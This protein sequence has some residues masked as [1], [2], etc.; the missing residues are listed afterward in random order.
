ML[1]KMLELNKALTHLNLSYNLI[2]DLGAQSIF[3]GLQH[4][5]T[6]VNLNLKQT[7]IRAVMTTVEVLTKMLQLNKALTHLNL[8]RNKSKICHI[9]RYLI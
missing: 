6:L 2:S 5:N 9:I 7:G 8:S 1:T 4:N 3:E